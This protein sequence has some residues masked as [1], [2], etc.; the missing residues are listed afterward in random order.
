[1]RITEN[2]LRVSEDVWLNFH[3]FCIFK[4]LCMWMQVFL[5]KVQDRVSG[6]RDFCHCGVGVV[7][8]KRVGGFL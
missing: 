3:E 4:L 6:C 7:C 5:E 1:M 8:W 2:L